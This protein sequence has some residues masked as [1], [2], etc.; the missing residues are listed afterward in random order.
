MAI[1]KILAPAGD[2]QS[3]K[4]AILAGAD[5]IY[6]GLNRFNAR[7]SAKNITSDELTLITGLG[8]QKNTRIFLTLNVLLTEPE[9]EDALLLLEEGIACGIDGVIVQDYGLIALIRSMYPHCEIHASTQMT[10]YDASKIELLA[11]MGVSRVNLSRELSLEEIKP[12]VDLCAELQMETEV[13]VHG[14]Y[15]FSFSGQCFMSS[16]MGGQSGNRGSCFQPCRRP[17]FGAGADNYELL[18]L[19]DNNALEL[20]ANL[21]EIGIHSLKIEGRL[22]DYFYVHETVKAWRTALDA[23]ELSTVP[24]LP[25]LNRVFNRNFDHGYLSKTVSPDMRSGSP[26][27][28]SVLLGAVVENY[29]ADQ[30]L[31]TI[32]PIATLPALPWDILI[33]GKDKRFVCHGYINTQVSSHEYRL[34]IE[35]RLL[36]HIE[37]G[38]TLGIKRGRES[39]LAIE[40]QINTLEIRRKPLSIRCSGSIGSYLHAEF[41]A[42]DR[43]ISVESESVLEPAKKNPL[44]A[45]KAHA[46]FSRIGNTS[47]ALESFQWLVSGEVFLPVSDLNAMRRRAIDTLDCQDFSPLASKPYSSAR[48]SIVVPPDVVE[49][50][51]SPANEI[52]TF[53][54]NNTFLDKNAGFFESISAHKSW[55]GVQV[56]V[57]YDVA[58]EETLPYE[59]SGVAFLPY[60]NSV[61]PKRTIDSAFR[62]LKKYSGVM[63]AS[64]HPGLAYKA[65]QLDKQVFLGPYANCTNG[66]TVDALKNFISLAGYIPS[67]ELNRTQTEQM[68]TSTSVPGSLYVFGIPRLMLT[69]QCLLRSANSCKKIYMDDSCYSHCSGVE[70]FYD[71]SGRVFHT[72]KEK[73]AFTGLYNHDA[74]F[75]HKAYQKLRNKSHGAVVDIRQISN[76]E[77]DETVCAIISM[78]IDILSD[79]KPFSPSTYPLN[80][81]SFSSGHDKRGLD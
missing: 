13:F 58:F 68:L 20:A 55:S 81:V 47:Y 51:S 78:L 71:S 10:V 3:A 39:R 7:R 40:Q 17:Y 26:Y 31:L 77:P 56:W 65:S 80:V 23:L 25:D 18:S 64:D 28:R 49:I 1:P 22:K 43:K 32:R 29:S 74:V 36:S 61:L 76:R 12:L 33:I 59:N 57:E 79:N 60:F 45:E 41:H 48:S 37:N 11:A 4:A 16:F 69:A 34:H 46:Q 24:E 27:D 63:I 66:A 35:G 52:L 9:L 6:L 67:I 14:A 72:L 5:E 42:G 54:C 19:K 30:S 62:F 73:N 53:I 15:C 70:K 21:S 38:N 44:D 2:V 75:L 50:S 8:H